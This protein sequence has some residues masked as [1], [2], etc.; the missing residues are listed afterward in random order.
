VVVRCFGVVVLCSSQVDICAAWLC[1]V[2]EL[3]DD[4]RRGCLM[5]PRGP[6]MLYDV[7]VWLYDVRR[8]CLMCGVV[9]CC[10]AWLYDLP[11]GCMM[12]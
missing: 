8:G 10:A 12:V 5:F 11:G 4:V 7:Q 9:V 1:H 2:V 3:W 6:V